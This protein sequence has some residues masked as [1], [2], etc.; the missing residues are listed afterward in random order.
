MAKKFSSGIVVNKYSTREVTYNHIG[1]SL[2]V[3]V[4]PPP[5]LPIFVSGG[6]YVYA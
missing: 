6:G 5:F 2:P 4:P 1:G 3:A